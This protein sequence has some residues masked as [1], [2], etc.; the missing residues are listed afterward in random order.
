M[1]T[2]P[3]GYWLILH[4]NPVVT[5]LNQLPL[6]DNDP[7]PQTVS[8]DALKTILSARFDAQASDESG[9]GPRIVVSGN[10]ATPAAAINLVDEAFA[11]ATINILNAIRPLPQRDG[12][13]LETSFVGPGMRG[14][15]NLRYLPCR[16]SMVPVLFRHDIRPDMVFLH[17]SK[18]DAGRLSLGI[19]VNILPGAIQYTR[20]NGGVV[21]A[22]SNANMPFTYGDAEIQLDDIDYIVEIDEPLIEV[23]NGAHDEVSAQIGATIAEHIHDCATLQLGI[24]AIPNAVLAHLK[25]GQLRVWTETFSDG[26][27]TLERA[28]QL[29]LAAPLRTSFLIGS[30]ELYDWA[31]QNPRIQMLRTEICNSPGHISE[32]HGMTSIN[33]ALQVDLYGQA[34]ASRIGKRVYSGFGG[35][36]DF[37]V[38]AMHATRGHSFM[39]LPSWHPKADVSTIVGQLSVPATSFQQNAVVTEQGIAWLFGEDEVQQTHN[40]IDHAAHPRARDELREFAATIRHW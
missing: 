21:V 4:P 13:T 39:A 19:E 32:N 40:L 2:Q 23:N 7:M 28:G 33:A 12:I 9:R 22:F 36:T 10:M 8:Y 31:D 37:I 5:A 26:V 16:L 38:G 1:T 30:R 24:G 3:G 15:P 11:R 17:T 27:L 25:A 6:S 14:A 29:D 20:A 35:S 18:P 34:N